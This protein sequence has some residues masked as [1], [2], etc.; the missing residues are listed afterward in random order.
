M[1]GQHHRMEWQKSD[2]YTERSRR[3]MATL[4]GISIS[5]PPTLNSSV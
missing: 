4:G 3:Q 5:A 1:G 2:G